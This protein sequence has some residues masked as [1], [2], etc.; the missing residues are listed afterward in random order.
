M[1]EYDI[2]LSHSERDDNLIQMIAYSLKTIGLEIYVEEYETNYGKNL[3]DSVCEAID[4]STCFLVVLTKQSINSQWVN[5]EIGYA[6]AREKPIIPV[7]VDKIKILG[8]IEGIKGIRSKS[9][10]EDL[11]SNIVWFFIEDAKILT[12]YVYC[13]KCGKTEEFNLP[14]QE[15]IYNWEKKKEPLIVQCD[16]DL[17]ITINPKTLLPVG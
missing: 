5:Q 2:F 8:M 6:Y 1:N 3:V 4:G 14:I 9:N 17:I 15:H 16:C 13:Q 12:F 10:T 7:K 11:I